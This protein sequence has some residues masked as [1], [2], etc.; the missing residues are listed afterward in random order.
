MIT[1]SALQMHPRATV[2][3]DEPA[4]SKLKMRDYYEWIQQKKPGAPPV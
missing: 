2:F 1:A 4:A 3:V